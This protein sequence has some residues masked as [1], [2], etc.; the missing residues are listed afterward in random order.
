[1][2]SINKQ[3]AEGNFEFLE[4]EAAKKKIKELTDKSSICFF[5]TNIRTGKPFDT[6]PMALQKLDDDGNLWFLS[7]KDSFKNLE[8]KQDPFV[9]LL[10]QGSEYTD[11]LQLYGEATLSDDQSLINELW[12]PL[13]K[14]W[15]TEGK[16]DPRIS[17][18]KV[19]PQEG[20][21]W[22]TKH[23]RAIGFIKRVAGA[24]IGKTMDDSIEG[25]LTV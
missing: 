8:L 1:M 19:V 11:F 16:D 25:K 13:F 17:I 21:Y 23:N 12:S 2:D 6:R 15:F 9:Q 18:I 4:G 20:Y 5:C 3:Q 7:A 22:D 10:F 14:T 24:V